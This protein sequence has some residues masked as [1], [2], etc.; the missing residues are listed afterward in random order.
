MPETTGSRALAPPSAH[1][2]PSVGVP[3]L[4]ELYFPTCSVEPLV[5]SEEDMG[6]HVLVGRP[7]PIRAPGWTT[8]SPCG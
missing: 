3:S 7:L 8:D 1:S 2:L 6:T 4:W 5:S